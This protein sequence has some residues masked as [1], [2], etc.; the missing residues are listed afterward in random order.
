MAAGR[1]LGESYQQALLSSA[2][3]LSFDQFPNFWI[4]TDTSINFRCVP[5]IQTVNRPAALVL[6]YFIGDAIS[7]KT[8]LGSEVALSI[9]GRKDQLLL[10]TSKCA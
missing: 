6:E 3:G 9:E 7:N 8:A 10:Q 5:F 2:Q 4:D 1:H